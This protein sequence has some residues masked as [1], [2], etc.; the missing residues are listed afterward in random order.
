MVENKNI[1]TIREYKE[2]ELK[3][4]V[5]KFLK[6]FGIKKF[7]VSKTPDFYQ[8]VMKINFI[9]Y[10]EENIKNDYAFKIEY[11][12]YEK[13]FVLSVEEFEK[14]NRSKENIRCSKIVN[15]NELDKYRHHIILKNSKRNSLKIVN[16]Y[17]K[18]LLEVLKFSKL[19][20]FG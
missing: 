20:I 16:G 17:I 2:T 11:L 12:K 3:S 18:E 1:N 6:D 15:M 13:A 7:N 14:E 8:K 9:F 19:E 10:S 5:E 4:F